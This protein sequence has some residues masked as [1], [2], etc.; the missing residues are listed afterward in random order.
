MREVIFNSARVFIRID[1]IPFKEYDRRTKT[2][3]KV[4]YRSSLRYALANGC[5]SIGV[6]KIESSGK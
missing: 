6:W 4:F 5:E 3:C 2:S 1:S